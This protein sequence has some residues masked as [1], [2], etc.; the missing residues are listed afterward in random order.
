MELCTE[1]GKN[2]AIT[3]Y[4]VQVIGTAMCDP[5]NRFLLDYVNTS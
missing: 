2:A 4:S 3:Q 5:I 1:L